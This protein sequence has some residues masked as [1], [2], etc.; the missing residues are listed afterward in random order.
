MV[1]VK[2]INPDDDITFEITASPEVWRCVVVAVGA[3]HF[4]GVSQENILK[5]FY[6]V[7]HAGVYKLKR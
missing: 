6:N 1:T 2:Q 5:E 3:Q 7:L 4:Y